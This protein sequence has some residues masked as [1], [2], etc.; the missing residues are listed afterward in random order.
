MYGGYLFVSAEYRSAA[1]ANGL[2]LFLDAASYTSSSLVRFRSFIYRT[3][4]YLNSFQLSCYASTSHY[5]GLERAGSE[6]RYENNGQ[7]A[8]RSLT[9][10][11]PQAK[12]ANS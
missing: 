10:G 1:D 4:T 6:L 2:D 9:D 11:R 8:C 12:F 7:A 3:M 5:L